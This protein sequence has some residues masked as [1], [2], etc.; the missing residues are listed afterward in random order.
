MLPAF[1][2]LG[3]DDDQNRDLADAGYRTARG[4]REARRLGRIIARAGA[5]RQARVDNG[6]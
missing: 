4:R 3:C 2:T 1:T 5:Q 6:R